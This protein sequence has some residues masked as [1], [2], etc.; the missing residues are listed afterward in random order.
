MQKGPR[1]WLVE[2]R[3]D[4]SQQ[5]IADEVTHRGV[6]CSRAWISLIELGLR[7]P[8]P[9]VAAVL[10]DLYQVTMPFI[11]FGPDGFNPKHDER[12]AAAAASQ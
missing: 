4:R 7:D 9:E 1:F 11:F 12:A 8:T 10:S 5:E 2:L 6:K 3:G